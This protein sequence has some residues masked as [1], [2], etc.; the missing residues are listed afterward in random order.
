M[1]DHKSIRAAVG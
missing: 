1:Q